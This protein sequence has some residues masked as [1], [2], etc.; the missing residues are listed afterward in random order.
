[1]RRLNR[2]VGFV[3][4]ADM[5]PLA[6]PPETAINLQSNELTKSAALAWPTTTACR[7]ESLSAFSRQFHAASFKTAAGLR[8]Q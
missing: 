5:V 3:P 2:H 8:L 7:V 4:N 1:M 6:L